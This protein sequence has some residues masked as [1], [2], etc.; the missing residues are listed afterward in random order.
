MPEPQLCCFFQFFEKIDVLKN[1]DRCKKLSNTILIKI[2]VHCDI[3]CVCVTCE[4]ESDD[5]EQRRRNLVV[6]LLF[7]VK[8][9][10][11]RRFL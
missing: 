10:R 6:G 8:Y 2:H 4:R 11:W 5:M 1:V 7:Y 3:R 9:L